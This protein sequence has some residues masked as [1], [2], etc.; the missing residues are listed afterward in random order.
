MRCPGS[1]PVPSPLL[2]QVST[3]LC[4]ITE[5]LESQVA[6]ICTIDLFH[7]G[8]QRWLFAPQQTAPQEEPGRPTE[9][10]SLYGQTERGCPDPPCSTVTLSWMSHPELQRAD[11]MHFKL[12]VHIDT[13]LCILWFILKSVCFSFSY[14][15]LNCL[16]A[17][18]VQRRWDPSAEKH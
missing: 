1:G 11:L 14:L 13:L 3:V 15:S 12:W 5:T 9:T 16:M 6:G 4:S 8:S 18:T 2:A 10:Q 17:V 7:C